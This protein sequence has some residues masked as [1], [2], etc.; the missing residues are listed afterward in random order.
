M[1]ETLNQNITVG[2]DEA[3]FIRILQIISSNLKSK[4][5]KSFIIN[6]LS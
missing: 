1:F 5:S 3:I 2:L 4:I 6:N